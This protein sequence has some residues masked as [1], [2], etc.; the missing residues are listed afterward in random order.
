MGYSIPSLVQFQEVFDH[1]KKTYFQNY[2]FEIVANFREN[3]YL[4]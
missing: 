1:K 2:L 4:F 3:T